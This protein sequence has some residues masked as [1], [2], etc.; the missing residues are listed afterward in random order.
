[1]ETIKV[2]LVGTGW[3]SD[4]H[5]QAWNRIPNVRVHALCNRSREKLLRK[6]ARYGVPESRCYASLDEMLSEGDID[7]VDIVTGPETHLEFVRKA[8]AAG[9]AILCQKPFSTNIEDAEAMVAAA[10]SAGV[11][12]MVTENWRWL[13]RFQT[14]KQVLEQ[15]RLG[16]PSVARYVHSDYYTPRMAPGVELPQPFFRD[17]PRLLFYEM[18]VHWFDTWRFLFGMPKRLYAET[19]SVSPHVQGDDS[20]IVVLGYDGFYGFLDMSWATRQRLDL[21]LGETV[22]PVHLEQL[23]IDGS[24][25]S[26][27]LYTDGRLTFVGKDGASEEELLPPHELDHEESHYRLQSHFIDSLRSGAP[28]QTGGA[29]NVETLR[30]AF[31]VYE[32][33][34]KHM[35]VT[36][37]G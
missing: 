29:D 5:L 9:K 15:G 30:L 7:V 3:W 2:G 26:L 6:A 13:Q 25:G 16:K 28:F 12:L 18:G 27:K 36:F 4:K 35:P 24:E 33:A 8:A 37:G 22:G 17:M 20:G 10:E 32:S 23:V 21:P 1:M 31:G 11:R 34:E 19:L 14:A